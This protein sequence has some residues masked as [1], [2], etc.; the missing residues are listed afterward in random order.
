MDWTVHSPW[1]PASGAIHV[2][3]E[4]ADGTKLE[5]TDLASITVSGGSPQT[6]SLTINDMS[7]TLGKSLD[8]GESIILSIKMS[9]ALVGTTQSSGGFPRTYTDSAS[10]TA[11]TQPFLSGD[12]TSHAIS[13]FFIAH[14]KVL[15]D[16]NG[17]FR[18]DIFDAAILAHAYGSR[19]EDPRWN[20]AADLDN[21]QVVN[22]LD[23]AQVAF[24]Y[25][26]KA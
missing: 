4:F 23:A 10:A 8:S 2:F 21:N 3:F 12:S 26:T 1:V 5:I 14:A 17:D 9:Y 11:Y 13:A 7:A 19:E 15:G 25:G 22:I 18:V 16:V 20:P 6:V 24:Y